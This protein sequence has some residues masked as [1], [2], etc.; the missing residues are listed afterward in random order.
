MAYTFTYL[1]PQQQDTANAAIDWFKAN[2]GISAKYIEV[3]AEVKPDIRL[4]PTFVARTNDHHTLCIEV[5]SSAYHQRLDSFILACQKDSLPVLMFVAVPKDFRDRDLNSNLKA[6]RT[7]G[8]GILE[9][10]KNSGDLRSNALSTS[11]TGVRAVDLKSFPAKYRQSLQQA[12]QSFRDGQPAKACSMVYDELEA[13]FFK[14][15]TKCEKNGLWTPKNPIS[16]YG[17]ANL[18]K[19]MNSLDRSHKGTKAVSDLMLASMLSVTPHRNESGHKPKDQ[20][21]LIKRDKRL[22]TR[23]ESA[24]DLLHEFLTATSSLKI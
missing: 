6:A 17:W 7:A 9:V 5:M 14:F 13:A 8:V 19:A 3:E 15:A 18:V 10:G 22:R 4:R 20:T 16:T 11:L 21:E 24:V 12:E 2:W 1:Q 23:F